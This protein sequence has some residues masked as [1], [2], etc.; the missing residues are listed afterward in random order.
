MVLGI[1]ISTHSLLIFYSKL[2]SCH[3]LTSLRFNEA[4]QTGPAKIYSFTIYLR[5]LSLNRVPV[6]A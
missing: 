4:S 3:L 1:F 6:N 2:S 5:N